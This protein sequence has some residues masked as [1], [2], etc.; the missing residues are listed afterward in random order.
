MSFRKVLTQ[1]AIAIAA[2]AGEALITFIL[3]RNKTA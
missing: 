3:N 1:S 2:I